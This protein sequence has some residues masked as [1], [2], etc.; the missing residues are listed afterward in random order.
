MKLIQENTVKSVRYFLLFFQEKLDKLKLLKNQ[1]MLVGQINVRMNQNAFKMIL[2]INA[3]V[4]TKVTL[5]NI[6]KIVKF[7]LKNSF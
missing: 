5:E 1:T 3:S 6:A 2:N 4:K 7:I